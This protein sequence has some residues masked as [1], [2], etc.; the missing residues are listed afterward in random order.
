MPD[1]ILVEMNSGHTHIVGPYNAT[2]M[3]KRLK[4]DRAEEKSRVKVTAKNEEE[5][6]RQNPCPLCATTIPRNS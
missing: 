6:R 5:A 4:V 2:E 1:Y 3:A